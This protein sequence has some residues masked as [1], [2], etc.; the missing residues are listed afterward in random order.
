MRSPQ[1][2]RLL[3]GVLFCAT[4][5]AACAHQAPGIQVRLPG[6]PVRM[7]LA[8]TPY[9]PQERYQCGPAALATVLNARGVAVT[10]DELVSQVYL[11]ARAGSLQIEIL[12]AI[13]RQ[14]LLAMP[15]ES[16]L[17]ALLAEIAAG[18]PVLV[19]QNLGLDW[20]PRW[21]YAVAIGYDLERQELVLRSGTEHRRITPLRVFLNTWNRSKRWGIVVLTPG[22]FPAQAKPTAYLEAAGA[23]ETLGKVKEARA[24][25][26][27]SVER[28][29]D[30]SVTWLGL[31]NTEYALGH[32]AYAEEAYRRAVR[33]QGSMAIS[34]NNLA[35]ALAAQQCIRS[36][37]EAARCA[38]SISPENA[39][40]THTLKEMESLPAP[41]AEH[42]LPLP[43]CFAH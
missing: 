7:E 31:G 5:L 40:F 24:A 1:C 29:P 13:R 28:W 43:N 23:L 21:H 10:P 18:N 4:L 25:Y 8:D 30:N 20:L 14:G 35:Y 9:F 36:A 12:S 2:A 38:T 37:R 26:K 3:A 17:D 34:W 42:C 33:I 15:I 6:L 41:T 16:T 27:A 39:E 11:P 32:A 22:V 19:L